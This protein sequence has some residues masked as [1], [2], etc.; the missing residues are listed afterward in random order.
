MLSQNANVLKNVAKLGKAM[1]PI[2]TQ[3]KPVDTLLSG[4]Q[5]D[6]RMT[7]AADWRLLIGDC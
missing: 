6:D 7:A 1:K 4:V 2:T 5:G 3:E